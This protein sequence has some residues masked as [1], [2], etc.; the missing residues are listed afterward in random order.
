MNIHERLD[1]LADA[2]WPVA[3][4]TAIVV[5]SIGAGVLLAEL[6]SA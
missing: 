3:V 2:I 1:R 6:V 4:V 5:I